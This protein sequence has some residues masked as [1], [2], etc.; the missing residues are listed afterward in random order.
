MGDNVATLTGKQTSTTL[1]SIEVE[2]VNEYFVTHGKPLLTS[3][4]VM[5]YSKVVIN[6]QTIQSRSMTRAVRTN[7][8]TVA[9]HSD[10]GEVAY[11]LVEKL[12]SFAGTNLAIIKQLKVSKNPSL[13]DTL[14]TQVA[15]SKLMEDFVFVEE[16]NSYVVVEINRLLM[17]CFNTSIGD[18]C[19]QLTHSVNSIE[20]IL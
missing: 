19:T 5:S 12:I 15:I 6:K 3:T 2:A 1:N 9:Y 16:L 14:S 18:Y 20:L 4:T 13:S 10:G 8:F 17:K 7:S 11:G